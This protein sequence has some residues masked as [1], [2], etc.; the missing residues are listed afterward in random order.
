MNRLES[1]TLGQLLGPAVA[2]ER[3]PVRVEGP[4]EPGKDGAVWRGGVPA[5]AA[6]PSAPRLQIDLSQG[7]RIG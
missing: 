1:A 4:D 6:H 2:L 5:P 3:V 7:A